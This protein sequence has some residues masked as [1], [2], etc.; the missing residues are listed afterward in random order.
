[1]IDLPYTKIW[2]P[3]IG[4]FNAIDGAARFTSEDNTNKVELF[5]NGRIIWEQMSGKLI[6]CPMKMKNFPFDIQ[7]CFIDIWTLSDHFRVKLVLD[8][9]QGRNGDT[10]F[11]ESKAESLNVWSIINT[12][13]FEHNQEHI[14]YALILK[15]K[16]TIYITDIII[17]SLLITLLSGFSMLIS[18]GNPNRLE[19]NLTVIVTTSVYQLMVSQNIPPTDILPVLNIYLLAQVILVYLSLVMNFVLWYVMHRLTLK[20]LNHRPRYWVFTIIVEW[21]FGFITLARFNILYNERSKLRHKIG[22][23][24]AKRRHKKFVLEELTK[25]SPECKLA[26]IEWKLVFLSID[27]MCAL[28]YMIVVFGFLIWVFEVTSDGEQIEEIMGEIEALKRGESD[29]FGSVLDGN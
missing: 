25:D 9:R 21:T 28:C 22:K 14:T 8:N 20:K 13:I 12:T 29:V 23:V 5:H 16:S 17:P 19:I 6:K 2:F 18:A 15:R 24:S 11:K 26:N 10:E 7:V 1:M 27:R 4:V 3:N